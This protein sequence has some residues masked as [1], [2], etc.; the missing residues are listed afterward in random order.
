MTTL[1]RIDSSSRIENSHSRALGDYVESGWRGLFPA[2]TVVNRDL[3][4]FPLEPIRQETIAGFYT[5]AD[6]MTPELREATALSDELISE[7]QSADMLLLTV[8]IYNFSIPAALKAWIDQVVRIGRT[9]SFDGTQ[10]GGLTEP[11]TAVICAAYGAMGY[12]RDG[13]FRAANFLEPYLEFLLTFLGVSN[14]DFV[15]L[16]ATTADEATVAAGFSTAQSDID[17]VMRTWQA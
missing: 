13:A 11:D 16:Q 5:P 12:E 3:A 14:V 1:L 2:G 7:V 8:P 10:F 15:S 17:R 4:R 9:F 6:Q